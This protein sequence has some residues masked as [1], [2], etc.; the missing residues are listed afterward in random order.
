M[1]LLFTKKRHCGCLLEHPPVP[2][3]LESTQRFIMGCI[4]KSHGEYFE[5]FF[6]CTLSAITHKLNFSERILIRTIQFPQC[7][8]GKNVSYRV[9]I[10]W[11]EE[12]E[13]RTEYEMNGTSDTS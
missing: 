7:L 8:G 10:S 9:L 6:K 13:V 5:N 2:R 4:Q 1:Q 11:L 3:H 12:I